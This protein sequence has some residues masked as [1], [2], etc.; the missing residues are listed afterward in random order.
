MPSLSELQGQMAAAL[1]AR[2]AAA[3]A[4]PAGWFRGAAE[5]GLHT[6]RNT[7]LGACCNALRLSYP[8]L[9][10]LLGSDVFEALAA[11][12]SCE[13]PPAA[14]LLAV[15]GEAFADFVAERATRDDRLLLHDAAR[16]DWLFERVAQQP[17]EEFG[18]Y[19]VLLP[20]GVQ[21]QLC[22]SLQLLR[23]S[24]AVDELRGGD[25][26]P[27]PTTVPMHSPHRLALWRGVD[28]VA[29]RRLGV[30]A[31]AVLERLLAGADIATALTA[32]DG[33][34]TP[35]ALAMELESDILRAGFARLGA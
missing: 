14:A 24:F 15:Y 11:D 23:V 3:R 4:L 10:R 21:L 6:H 32:A 22:N 33:L 17:A 34:A 20:G 8:T 31:L 12:F 26:V 16:F 35:E 19:A 25:S 29:V 7:V 2:T 27:A 28:G 5:R 30:A 1:L 18:R 13:Q 9:E